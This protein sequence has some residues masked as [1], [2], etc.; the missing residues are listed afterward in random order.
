MINARNCVSFEVL[1]AVNMNITTFWVVTPCS[2]VCRYRHFGGICSLSFLPQ[3]FKHSLTPK[4]WYLRPYYLGSQLIYSVIMRLLTEAC[5]ICFNI[6]QRK[7]RRVR[8]QVIGWRD[9]RDES[10]MKEV[11][12]CDNCME[13]VK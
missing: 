6:K 13:V 4:P 2:L 9:K 8:G 10:R 12:E 11:N 3:G 1:M 7:N 5:L